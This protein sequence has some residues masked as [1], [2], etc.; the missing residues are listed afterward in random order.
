MENDYITEDA[1]KDRYLIFKIDDSF[2]GIEIRHVIEI[3]GLQPITSIPHQQNF[4]KG[5]IN[6]RGKIIPVIDV[7]L[8][9][10]KPFKEYNDRTCIIVINIDDIDAGLIVDFVSEVLTIKQDELS[11]P[12]E[13]FGQSESSFI[14]SI[15]KS[16]DRLILILDSKPLI[17]TDDVR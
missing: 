5:V 7:R 14:K 2:Y 6:L 8:R 13:N 16:S 11:V 17:F 15:A 9:L 12:P 4:V 10:G 1:M 3:I